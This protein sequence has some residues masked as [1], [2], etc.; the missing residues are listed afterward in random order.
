MNLLKQDY[1]TELLEEV[2]MVQKIPG[3]PV[4]VYDA[5]LAFEVGALKVSIAL[6][7][8][9]LGIRRTKTHNE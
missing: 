4:E 2:K 3:F 1:I 9:E 5:L 7:H 6:L 8:N